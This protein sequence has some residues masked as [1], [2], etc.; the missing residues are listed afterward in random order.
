M[1]SLFDP[2]E[3]RLSG[4]YSTESRTAASGLG[5]PGRGETMVRP[6]VRRSMSHAAPT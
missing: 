3:E 5:G 1:Q 4:P 6:Y 2:L